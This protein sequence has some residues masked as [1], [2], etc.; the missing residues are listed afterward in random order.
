MFYAPLDLIRDVRT[1]F[2]ISLDKIGI[3]DLTVELD[4]SRSLFVGIF[5]RFALAV[6]KDIAGGIG[7]FHIIQLRGNAVD[8]DCCALCLRY[9][10]RVATDFRFGT[11]KR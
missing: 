10:C 7:H 9:N 4:F 6:C 2:G 1:F 11:N 5:F 3:A 8:G